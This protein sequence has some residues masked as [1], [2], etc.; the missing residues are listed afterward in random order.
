M[1]IIWPPLVVRSWQGVLYE[2][3]DESFCGWD[4]DPKQ[5]ATISRR[6]HELRGLVVGQVA[7]IESALLDIAAE[8][9]DRHPG[10]LPSRQK[11]KGAGGALNDVRKLLSALPVG[12]GLARR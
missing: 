10:P 8:I 7:E 6:M 5:E 11:W 3:D 2:R 12:E 4:H 1:S 9:R